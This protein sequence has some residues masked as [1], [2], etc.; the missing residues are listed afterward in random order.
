MEKIDIYKKIFCQLFDISENEL[1]NLKY[2]G[3]PLWDSV[4]H[5]TLISEVEKYFKIEL[6]TEDIVGFSSYSKGIQIL[7]EHYGI[8]L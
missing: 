2:K 7:K 1:E 5:M 3:N 4:G 8:D 6:K